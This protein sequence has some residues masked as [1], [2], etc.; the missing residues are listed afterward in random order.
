MQAWQAL[1]SIL[2]HVVKTSIDFTESIYFYLTGEQGILLNY[3]SL[4]PCRRVPL[5]ARLL[6]DMAGD[7]NVDSYQ[8]KK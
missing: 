6:G 2:D 7:E 5:H 1:L 3:R 4:T 8:N